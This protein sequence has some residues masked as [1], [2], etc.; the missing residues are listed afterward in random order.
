M[1]ESE[2]SRDPTRPSE[3]RGGTAPG[4]DE[5]RQKGPWAARA[6]EGVVPPEL[7]GSDAPAERLGED[8]ELGSGVL[9]GPARSQ[10]PA[11]EAGID[12]RGGEQADATADGAPA[13]SGGGEPDL[14]DAARGPRQVD[15]ESAR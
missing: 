10:A 7:G 8:P 15:V 11:T 3:Q 6:D 9:G 2:D 1:T 13:A 12:A 4:E 5:A 14:K